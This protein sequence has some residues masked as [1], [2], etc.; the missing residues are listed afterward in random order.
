[1]PPIRIQNSRNSVE[2]EGRIQLAIQAYQNKEIPTIR[3]AARRFQVPQATLR[4]RYNG[5]AFRLETHTNN[6][7]L[8]QTEEESL[9]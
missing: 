7:K 3:E 5:Q 6:H 1:M 8:T 9:L 2:Q 4:H